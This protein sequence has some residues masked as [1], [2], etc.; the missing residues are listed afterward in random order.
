M[1]RRLADGLPAKS[2]GA[3]TGPETLPGTNLAPTTR[4]L[5]QPIPRDPDPREAPWGTRPPPASLD[6]REEEGL[7]LL[8]G[9]V[10]RL[11]HLLKGGGPWM[12]WVEALEDYGRPDQAIA[13]MTRALAARPDDAALAPEKNRR[14]I[15]HHAARH[16]AEQAGGGFVALGREVEVDVR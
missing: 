5:Y 9:R 2:L 3:L 8:A 10:E 16:V 14:L 13:A 15:E 6:M 12:T 11:G 4:P 7:A 1:N